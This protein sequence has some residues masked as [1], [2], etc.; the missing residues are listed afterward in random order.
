MNKWIRLYN[1][2]KETYFNRSFHVFLL[3]ANIKLGPPSKDTSHG[4]YVWYR[5]KNQ[6]KKWFVMK[7]HSVS[8]FLKWNGFF[9][10]SSHDKSRTKTFT[11]TNVNSFKVVNEYTAQNEITF[12]SVSCQINPINDTKSNRF[13]RK[14]SL[15]LVMQYN[16]I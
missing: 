7:S 2:S 16:T 9:Y 15:H 12:S 14:R 10:L 3:R 13:L 5:I 8:S 6:L 4:I 1:F 11:A